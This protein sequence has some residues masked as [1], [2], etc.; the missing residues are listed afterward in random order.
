VRGLMASV[1]SEPIVGIWGQSPRQGAGAE[2]LVR[3]SGDKAPM[4]LKAFSSFKSA[5]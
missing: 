4:K 1:D 2:P 3:G 5:N